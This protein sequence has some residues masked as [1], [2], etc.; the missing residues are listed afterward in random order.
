MSFIH[1]CHCR[2]SGIVVCWVVAVLLVVPGPASALRCFV[3]GG[4][5]GTTCR[6]GIGHSGEAMEHDITEPGVEGS[7][8]Q[9][10]VQECTDLINNRGCVK[11]FVNGGKEKIKR[12]F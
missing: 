11:Q 7:E 10:P 9:D 1:S 4:H 12:N 6:G 3:C 8:G 5:S 2:V